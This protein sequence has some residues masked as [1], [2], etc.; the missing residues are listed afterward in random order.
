VRKA[1]SALLTL[2]W[3]L[4]YCTHGSGALDTSSAQLKFY[5]K[6]EYLKVRKKKRHRGDKR[7]EG[8]EVRRGR[9]ERKPG[10]RRRGEVG[11]TGKKRKK[12]GLLLFS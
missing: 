6:I 5:G 8:G 11:R 12:K 2:K 1:D 10:Q 7:E 3:G 9:R 4:R